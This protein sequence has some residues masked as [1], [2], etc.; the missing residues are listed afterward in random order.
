MSTDTP[1]R[2]DPALVGAGTSNAP[3]TTDQVDHGRAS[4][5][6]FTTA[7]LSELYE[8]HFEYVYRCL[9]AM[10]VHGD[11]VDDALQDVFVVVQQKLK[12]FDGQAHI[13]TWLYAIVLRIARRYRE[14]FAKDTRRFVPAGQEQAGGGEQTVVHNEQ[15]ALAQ[16]ALAM[17]DPAKREVFVLALVEQ[18]SAPEIACV[19]GLPLNT[20]YS[21]LRAAKAAFAQSVQR[22]KRGKLRKCP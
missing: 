9:R 8:T 20:V 3:P 5:G 14:R 10:G 16:Q 22:I 18:C 1:L 7:S 19:T 15:L 2:L 17:L 13:R 12:E 21:R 4:A 6:S 11:S